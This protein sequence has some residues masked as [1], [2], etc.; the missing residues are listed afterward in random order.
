MRQRGLLSTLCLAPPWFIVTVA[1]GAY[2]VMQQ[3]ALLLL[4]RLPQIAPLARLSNAAAPL[5]A[6]VLLLPLP[7]AIWR[8]GKER[9]LVRK[10]KSIEALR[11][12]SWQELEMLVRKLFAQQGYS[13]Q[14][15]GGEGA[16]GGI[17]VVLRRRSRTILVQCKQ[18]TAKQVGVAVVRELAGVIAV[19]G[20]DGGVVV[21][22]GV[23]TRDA[24]EFAKRAG[25]TLIDGMGL[26]RMRNSGTAALPLPS[27][28]TAPDVA[29]C[30]CP[31]C[32]ARMV[33]RT[34]PDDGKPFLGCSNYP[35]CYGR[36]RL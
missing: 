26:L 27:H 18:W 36:R 28:S 19:R 10:I 2:F 20:A 30:G 29:L 6:A 13:A 15:I 31:E 17:D 22:C 24:H 8:S 25:I 23:F 12:V 9:R 14:R 5:V 32:G 16:D 34:S 4:E 1:G 11:A 21:T 35:G 7:V 33:R 3:L